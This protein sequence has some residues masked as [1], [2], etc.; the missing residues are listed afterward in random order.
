MKKFAIIYGQLENDIQKRAVEELSSTLLDYTFEY[1]VCCRYDENEN[2]SDYKRIYI[3]TKQ[4]NAYI[5]NT[6]KRILSKEEEYFIKVE[7]S[8][9]VIEGFDDA[10][11]LYGVLDF[12]NKYIVKYEHPENDNDDYWKNFLERDEL[13]D[14]EY[15]SAPS[16][17]ERGLWTWGHVIYDYRGYFDNMMK[18]KMNRVIIWNDFAPVNADDIVRYAHSCNIK[19]IW[20]FS[21]LWDTCCNKFDLKNLDAFS[22]DILETYERE[23]EKIGGDGIYFQTFTEL[24]KDNIGGVLIAEAAAKFVNKTAALFYEKHPDIELQFGLHATSVNNRLDFIKA[25]DSRIRIVWEDCGAFP[26]SYLPSNLESFDATKK[27]VGEISSLRGKDDRFG[28]VTKGLVKLDWLQFEHAHGPQCIGLS[29]EIM[30]RNRIE[31]KRRIWR[32]IQAGWL[33]NADKAYEMVQEMLHVKGE[34]FCV[35]ALVEDGMFEEN[36]M[37]PVA[38]YS[39]MLWNCHSDAKELMKDVALR[40][41]VSFA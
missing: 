11:V 17:K 2:L 9:I 22:K 5:R 8:N 1:P 29:S 12:Y 34:D 20:G 18:L 41:Y 38:L 26:F 36:I 6:S 16:I 23:Y 35:F 30:K 27:F 39:E 33:K 4:S 28:V 37:Y 40:S 15:A 10:G 21:W 7:N 32:Y 3:G 25:V 19:I 13:P 31:R 14:F 24:R